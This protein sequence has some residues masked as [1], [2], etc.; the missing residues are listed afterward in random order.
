MGEIGL[1]VSPDTTSR[2]HDPAEADSLQPLALG[3]GLINRANSAHRGATLREA[4]KEFY[5][6]TRRKTKDLA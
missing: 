2:R 5:F 1:L 3:Q 6:Q 4:A